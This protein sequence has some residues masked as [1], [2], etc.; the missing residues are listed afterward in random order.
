MPSRRSRSPD[1]AVL[2]G[3]YLFL[4]W[5]YSP[6]T[7]ASEPRAFPNRLLLAVLR[8]K[9]SVIVVILGRPCSFLSRCKNRRRRVANGENTP[10][11]NFA[12]RVRVRVTQNTRYPIKTAT[13]L[14]DGS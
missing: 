9:F 7:T 10:F 4:C 1:R 14:Q 12:D 13:V 6:C 3:M 5:G 11:E 2:S 8:M